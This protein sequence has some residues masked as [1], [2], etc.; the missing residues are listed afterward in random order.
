MSPDRGQ[1]AQLPLRLRRPSV[2][3]SRDGN[4]A[5]PDQLAQ[6]ARR[7]VRAHVP[8][9]LRPAHL[10]GGAARA[11]R[12]RR[13]PTRPGRRRQPPAAAPAAADLQRVVHVPADPAGRRPGVLRPVP[14]DPLR[15]RPAPPAAVR[16]GDDPGGR[17]QGQRCH[18]PEVRRRRDDRR[19]AELP[20]TVRAEGAVRQ[21][22]GPGADRV[23]RRARDP[24][25]RQR[26]H[27]AAAA[28]G[29][30]P[31]T[32]RPRRAMSPARSAWTRTTSTTTCTYSNGW[33]MGRAAI[34]HELGHV[35]GL[36]HV[37]GPAAS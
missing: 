31:R 29:R 13:L 25:P 20:A 36:G 26:R 17:R 6:P 12:R 23:Q 32:A 28:A 1:S 9:D 37:A 16:R 15:D 10:A 2:G 3:G 21:P 11:G 4:G 22:L 7:C 8:A 14:P 24:R 27:G 35:V 33:A 34:M 5:G 18:R 30:S 19:A